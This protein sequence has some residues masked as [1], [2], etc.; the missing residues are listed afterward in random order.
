[1]RGEG[2]GTLG[3]TLFTASDIVSSATHRFQGSRVGVSAIRNI[4][5]ASGF[6]AVEV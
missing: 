4:H 6:S 3:G 1:M 2:E 5:V